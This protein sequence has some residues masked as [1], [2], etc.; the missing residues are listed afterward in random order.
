MQ[1]FCAQNVI[2]NHLQNSEGIL[3]KETEKLLLFDFLQSMTSPKAASEY[4]KGPTLEMNQ[5]TEKEARQ[6]MEP[7]ELVSAEG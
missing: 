3:G 5:N 7:I 2:Q 1:L 6:T 4:L